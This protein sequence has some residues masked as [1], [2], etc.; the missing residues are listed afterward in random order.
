M[1]EEWEKSAYGDVE[2]GQGHIVGDGNDNWES[3]KSANRDLV[4]ALETRCVIL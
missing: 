2:E 1:E 3:K 4:S